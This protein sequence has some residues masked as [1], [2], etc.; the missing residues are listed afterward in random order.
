MGYQRGISDVLVSVNDDEAIRWNGITSMSVSPI[1]IESKPVYLDGVLRVDKKPRTVYTASI[2]CY[3]YPE[4]LDKKD[5]FTGDLCYRTEVDGGF[6]IHILYN[7]VV[8]FDG[9]SNYET[10]VE[11]TPIDFKWGVYGTL[12]QSDVMFTEVVIDSRYSDEEAMS[13][14]EGE[15]YGDNP[16]IPDIDFIRDFIESTATLIITDEG[17]GI[18]TAEGPDRVV[19]LTSDTEFIIDWPSVILFSDVEFEVSSL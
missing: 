11:E 6:R 18:Y 15:I 19:Y 16:R 3:T 2:S 13:V 14:I 8:K 7:V 10:L 1:R 12:R 4:E 5:I 17:D 9:M